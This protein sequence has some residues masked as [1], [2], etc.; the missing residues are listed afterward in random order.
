MDTKT[1]EL[2]LP[3]GCGLASLSVALLFAVAL[4]RSLA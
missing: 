4:G 1:T 3:I 2:W